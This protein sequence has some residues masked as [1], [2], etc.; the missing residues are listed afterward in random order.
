MKYYIV[1]R[2]NPQLPRPYFTAIGKVSKKIAKE[3]SEAVYGSK[4]LLTY[5][6]KEEYEEMLKFFK[7]SGYRVNEDI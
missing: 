2:D 3:K 7:N 1:R 4:T 5:D 6:T